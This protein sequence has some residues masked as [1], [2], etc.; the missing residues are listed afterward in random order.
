[1]APLLTYPLAQFEDLLPTWCWNLLFAAGLLAPLL[2][3]M[4][5]LMTKTMVLWKRI[6]VVVF[7]AVSLPLAALVFL[8]QTNAAVHVCSFIILMP[9]GLL[10]GLA[11]LDP[12]T[13]VTERRGFEVQQGDDDRVG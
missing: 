12:G 9:V 6:A 1:M 7:Y 3:L 10:L 13:Q 11:V 8:A 2:G 4:S 5:S